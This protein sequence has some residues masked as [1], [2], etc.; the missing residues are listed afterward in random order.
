MY[1]KLFLNTLLFSVFIFFLLIQFNCAKNEK[2]NTDNKNKEMSKSEMISRGKYLVN[3]GGC[4]DCH[5]PKTF[6]DMGPVPDNSKLLSGHPAGNVLAKV[7]PNLV[8]PG[9]WYLAANDLTAWVGPWGISYTANLTPDDPTGIGTWTEEIFIKAL[10]T[11]KHMG[12]GRPL[13]P[14]MPWQAIGRSTDEDLKSIFAYL[15]S[16]PAIN[17]KVPDPVPP[18]EIAKK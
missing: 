11:G 9:M 15:K 8:K 12:V 16:L 18:N 7:D 10:R 4:D 14:P 3:L 6:S 17:N 5:S 1:K 2:E 13:L